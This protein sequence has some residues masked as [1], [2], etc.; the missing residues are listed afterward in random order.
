VQEETPS[1]SSGKSIT[2]R[3]THLGRVVDFSQPPTDNTWPLEENGCPG[4]K[5]L[6]NSANRCDTCGSGLNP[7]SLSR[8][9]QIRCEETHQQHIRYEQKGGKAARRRA[10]SALV[11]DGM[12]RKHRDQ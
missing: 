8:T 1:N 12:G 5:C 6:P 9:C 3:R 7:N 10:D 4:G 11:A 2:V